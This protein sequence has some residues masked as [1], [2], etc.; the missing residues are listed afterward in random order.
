VIVSRSPRIHPEPVR[1]RGVK[2]R[3]AMCVLSV[4]LPRRGQSRIF[5]LR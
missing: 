5:H 4:E 3:D 2:G 1:E